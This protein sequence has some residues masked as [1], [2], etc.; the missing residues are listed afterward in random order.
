MTINTTENTIACNRD[1][2]KIKD[3]NCED[4]QQGAVCSAHKKKD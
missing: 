1:S 2:I 3:Q 4:F